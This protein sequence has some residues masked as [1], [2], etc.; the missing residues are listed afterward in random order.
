MSYQK[1]KISIVTVVYN[2]EK[3][4]ERT[5]LSVINA[6]ENYQNIEYLIIDGTSKDKTLEIISK[7][8]PHID[9]LLTEPDKG[10]YDA[11]NKGLKHSTG[12]YIWFLNS[13]DKIHEP[14]TINQFFESEEQ[15]QDVYYGETIMVDENE[16]IIGMRRLT[17]PGKLTW[18]SFKRG[19]RV[20]HQSII[21][22]KDLTADYDLKYRFSA[23]FDWCIKALKKSVK[24]KNTKL[25]FTSYLDGGLTKHN[26]VAG[27]KE[28]FRIMKK[29]YGLISTL[30]NHI[31]LGI[32]FL[33]FLLRNKRF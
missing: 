20:S 5:I 4:I 1:P 26:I 14:T 15:L 33:W 25:I 28:R 2:S 3:F 12:D 7:F 24:I 22:R 11:M 23:D 10:L 32:N 17:T 30:F 6:K 9:F 27:L 16:Q 21:F 19:M 8:K 31:P 29:H 13:G 18:K